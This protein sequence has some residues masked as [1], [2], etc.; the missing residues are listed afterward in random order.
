MGVLNALKAK[1]N[2]LSICLVLL[3]QDLYENILRNGNHQNGSILSGAPANS[4]AG[5]AAGCT[6]LILI[7]TL[8]IAHTRLTA[9]IGRADVRQFRGIFHFLTTIYNKDGIRGVYRGLPAFLHGMVVHRS[10]YFGG[11]D[12][13]KEI[14]SG[15]AAEHGL[16]PWKRWVVAQAVTA[17]AGLM[18]YPLDSGY[19]S[20]ADD[21]AIWPGTTN[22]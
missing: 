2:L 20:K 6:T 19:S 1:Q 12:T 17:S 3:L 5:A 8:E 21:D 10:L 16:A 22:V 4:I 18:S 9:D 15:E 13:L 14:L 11:F 7:Y